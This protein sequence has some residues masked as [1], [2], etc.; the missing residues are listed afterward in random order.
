[1]LAALPTKLLFAQKEAL[2][3]AERNCSTVPLFVPR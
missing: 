1:V 2:V 3:I